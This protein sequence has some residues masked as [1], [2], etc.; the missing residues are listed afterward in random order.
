[1]ARL[2][3]IAKKANVSISTV[4]RVLNHD[5]AFSISLTNRQKILQI[6]EELDYPVSTPPV[7]PGKL[8]FEDSV[9]LILLYDE[10]EE[11]EDPYYL[12]IRTHCKS[13]CGALGLDVHEYYQRSLEN[14][15]P[16]QNHGLFIFIGSGSFW[17]PFIA[18]QVEKMKVP[19]IL[20]D[21]DVVDKSPGTDVIAIDMK[22]IMTKGLAHLTA[23]GYKTVGFIGSR[24]FSKSRN[25]YVEDQREMYFRQMMEERGGLEERWV[26][27][28]TETTLNSGY[29]LAKE[30]ISRGSLPEAFFVETDTMA[31]GVVKA[32][33][34]QGIMVPKDIGIVSC[35]DIPEAQYLSPAL[36]T[37][38]I[39][40]ALM[41]IMTAR[42]AAE[43]LLFNRN[44][45]VKLVI[46]TELVVR[47]SCGKGR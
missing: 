37:I 21:F 33:K 12:S 46:P 16:V 43:K 19:P 28:A 25:A 44:K 45:G 18:E 24:D 2:K 38:K 3:D 30:A 20:V 14:P 11:V 47:E 29:T 39:H 1:M 40:T 6:A 10:M 26:L 9:G 13:E 22:D 4:S 23:Q 42:L 34:E 41:G 7:N 31:I 17:T 36:T 32:F 5:P 35:N 27:T 8:K 15:L